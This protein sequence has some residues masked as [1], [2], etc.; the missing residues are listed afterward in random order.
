[1]VHL[2]RWD[3]LSHPVCHIYMSIY[4]RPGALGKRGCTGMDGTKELLGG[5][6]PRKTT[7][8]VQSAQRVRAGAKTRKSAETRERI[9]KAAS[10]LMAEHGSIDFQMGEVSDRCNMS[11]GSL[12]YY[13]VDK[14]DLVEAI[15]ERAI[16]ELMASIKKVVANASTAE[17]ALHGVCMEYASRVCSGSPVAMAMM[18]ELVQS[19][20][21]AAS[22]LSEPLEGIVGIITQELELAQEDGA[23]REDVDCRLA[24]LS[25]CGSFTFAAIN[26]VG[27]NNS[28]M[29]DVDFAERLFDMI[30]SGFGVAEERRVV[31]QP[32][33]SAGELA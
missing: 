10:D 25:L 15:F 13:F 27:T 8:K 19:R 28:G 6:S 32:T 4:A 9:M 33:M 16:D 26:A 1:M 24:A 31:A 22:H 20:G 18:R 11:K 3:G 2:G 23:V 30:F 5:M 21:Q 14:D 7:T 17:D 29:V 12:Y